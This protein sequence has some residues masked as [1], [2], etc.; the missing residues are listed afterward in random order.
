M[1]KAVDL[2]T[3]LSALIESTLPGYVK[4]P[5]SLDSTDNP[6]IHLEK[7]YSIGYSG[8]SNASDNFCKGDVRIK[9]NYQVVLTNV[10]VANLD[11]DYRESL[12]NQLIN[13][14]FSLVAAIE[15]EPT[16]NGDCISAQFE[17]DNGIEYLISDEKQFI[18]IVSNILIDYIERV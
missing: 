9:R 7:G 11:A 13:D 15:C 8:A 4:L 5:D 12:E 18:I 1:S 3:S 14:H 10:Y 17:N 2:R 6:Y 16:L